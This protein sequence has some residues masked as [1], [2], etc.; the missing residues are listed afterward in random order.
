MRAPTVTRIAVGA[1]MPVL[2][3]AHQPRQ[4]ELDLKRGA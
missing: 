4:L 1:S 2:W 3:R